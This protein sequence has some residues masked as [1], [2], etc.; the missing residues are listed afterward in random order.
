M[1]LLKS[2]LYDY[3]RNELF[4]NHNTERHRKHLGVRVLRRLT[5]PP[6]NGNHFCHCLDD[7]DTTVTT[8]PHTVVNPCTATV[9]R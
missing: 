9:A 7:T 1:R 6:E 2:K 5:A 3:Y 8:E 4:S